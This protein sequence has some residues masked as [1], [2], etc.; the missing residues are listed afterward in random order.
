[1]R[2]R[3]SGKRQSGRSR[4]SQRGL[5]RQTS[6]A[7]PEWL[8]ERALLSADPMGSL[9][10]GPSTAPDDAGEQDFL[11]TDLGTYENRDLL[12]LAGAV[13]ADE[14]AS[15][16]HVATPLR[17]LYSRELQ[18]NALPL[19]EQTIFGTLYEEAFISDGARPHVQAFVEDVSAAAVALQDLGLDLTSTV[20]SDPWQIVAGFLPVDQNWRGGRSPGVD[21][22]KCQRATDYRFGR[23]S[24]ECCRGL[25]WPVVCRP[26][27]TRVGYRRRRRGHRDLLRQHQSGR[28]RGCRLAGNR[29]STFRRSRVD[30]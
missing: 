21:V 24:G 15:L 10:Q 26:V 12:Y 3:R 22:S 7:A 29:R 11:L 20:D 8:E 25:G 13:G 23:A 28:R 1:M 16:Q 18:D 9:F 27:A 5:V 19:G 6:L 30:P 17:M 14:L 2:F 4:F